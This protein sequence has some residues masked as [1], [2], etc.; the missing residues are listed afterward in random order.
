MFE[1]SRVL[2]AI[3]TINSQIQTITVL[4]FSLAIRKITLKKA[5]QSI[6]K[7]KSLHC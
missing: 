6:L 7:R 4:H 5:K 1:I 3:N 2:W